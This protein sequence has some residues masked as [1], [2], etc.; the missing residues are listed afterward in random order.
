VTNGSRPTFAA[1]FAA[2]DKS[3]FVEFSSLNTDLD[4]AL[5]VMHVA[6]QALGEH[7]L[8]PHDIAIALRD[9]MRH[10]I[11]RQ[12][13][14]AFLSAAS[15]SVAKQRRGNRRCYQIMQP[16]IDR[17][18][19]ARL[20]VLFIQPE[21]A[22]TRV[23]EVQELLSGACGLVKIC[24]PYLAPRSLDFLTNLTKATEVR[25]LTD[26]IDKPNTVRRDLKP[27]MKELGSP[28]EVRTAPGHALHDRYVID[29]QSMLILGTSLNGIGLK[30]A[31]VISVG[32]DLRAAADAAFDSLWVASA[33]L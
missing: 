7:V 6:D 25:V 1:T 4:R 17:V 16:G 13:V 31:M 22:L 12:R 33:T 3:S 5:W 20:A 18:E 28:V 15:G 19:A 23:R 27:L 11:S 9:V 21:Q 14:E 10:D 29:D 26:R 24:D 32:E 30:Q 2:V 8:A